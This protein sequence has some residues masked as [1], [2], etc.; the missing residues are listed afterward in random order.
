M[1]LFMRWC[2]LVV[3]ACGSA[4]AS[5]ADFFFK[6]GDVVVMIGDSITEQHL[7]SN[8]VEM[9]AVTRFPKWK[10]TF[11]NVGIGGDTSGGGNNRFARDVVQFKH[12]DGV[13][14]TSTAGRRES[15]TN[16]ADGL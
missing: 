5:A 10:L 14:D 13:G 16:R 1:S 15:G 8:Y 7:Y 6:D 12:P 11:R 3:L 2:F 4:S 9:W